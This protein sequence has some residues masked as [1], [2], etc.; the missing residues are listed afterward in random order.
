[1]LLTTIKCF[2]MTS[3]RP[4]WC[5][6]PVL[7]ELNSFL[8]LFSFVL[9]NWNLHRCW[10]REWKHSILRLLRVSFFLYTTYYCCQNPSTSPKVV[11]W[12]YKHEPIIKNAPCPCSF[13]KSQYL[14]LFPYY[15]LVEQVLVFRVFR[16][17]SV[18]Y[19]RVWCSSLALRL[20]SIAVLYACM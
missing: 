16:A 2:H 14:F 10:P 4:Y 17:S 9:I 3:R 12:R 6:K 5:P 8:I 13:L 7:W 19:A 15:Q 20:S 18:R 11:K 1:M